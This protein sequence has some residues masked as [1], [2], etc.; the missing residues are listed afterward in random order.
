MTDQEF[1]AYMQRFADGVMAEKPFTELYKAEM[2]EC[3]CVECRR[4][5]GEGH[6]TT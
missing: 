3:G 5:L 2:L 1:K 4:A 6:E